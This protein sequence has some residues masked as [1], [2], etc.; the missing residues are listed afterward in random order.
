[1]NPLLLHD[2]FFAAAARYP[3]RVAVSRGGDARTFGE[4]AAAVPGFARALAGAGVHRGDRVGCWSDT[5]LDLVPLYF[6]CAALGATFTPANPA[7]G[8]DEVRTVFDLADP[9]LVVVDEAHDG[10]VRLD[11]LA[12]SPAST[13]LPSG[14]VRETDGHIMFFT[15]GTTGTPKAIELSHRTDMLRAL[16]SNAEFPGGATASMFPL[17]H[18]SG[19]TTANAPWLRGEEVVFADGAD[20]AGL[21]AAIE[22]RRAQRFYGIP[23]VWRRMLDVDLSEFDL[24]SLRHADTGT[25]ATTIELLDAIHQALPHTTTSV[26]YGSTEAGAVCRLAFEDIHRK[27]G[28]VGPAQPGVFV[29]VDEDGDLWTRSPFLF[30]GY[31]RN[32][33][34]T[35]SALVDGWYRT[36]ELAE[37]DDDGYVRIVGRS[38]EM[39]RTGGE[40][41]APAEVDVVLIDHEAVVDAAVAGVPHDDWGEVVT[42]FVVVRPGTTLTLEDL[43]RHCDGRLARFKVPRKLVVVDRIPRTGATRQ[44]QRRALLD[45]S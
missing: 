31:F 36:G 1:M 22:R 32:P 20:A 16:A 40:T 41:V 12:R 39:I 2:A 44:V 25:S 28:S 7:F 24:S 26:T 17:F 35:A 23:A 9:G 11:D 38:T 3:T 6:A 33:E 27:P 8:D 43:Q 29:R 13:G 37:I 34:A 19:W 15:S 4:V 14:P 21:L 5:N 30:T 18:M 42:A 10:D 45:R